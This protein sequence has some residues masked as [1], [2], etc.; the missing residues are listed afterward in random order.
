MCTLTMF[1]PKE[2]LREAMKEMEKGNIPE[3]I[4][5]YKLYKEMA[6]NVH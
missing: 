3:Y 2:I 5:L 1:Q 4:K 6:E